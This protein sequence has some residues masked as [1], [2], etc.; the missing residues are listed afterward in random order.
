MN[1]FNT[2][3]VGCSTGNDDYAELTPAGTVNWDIHNSIDSDNTLD[4]R[5]SGHY[6]CLQGRTATDSDTPGAG[7]WVV[8]EDITSSPY[9]LR[10]KS[11][12]ENDAQDA[13][14]D[15]SGA[16][17]NMPAAVTMRVKG[18]RDASGQVCGNI[19][20]MRIPTGF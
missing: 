9:D 11:N 12:A 17:I 13:H 7:T 20:P 4:D 10:L 5:D 8:F 14:T 15:S 6:N 19:A 1:V 16:G 2:I 3:V 18:L